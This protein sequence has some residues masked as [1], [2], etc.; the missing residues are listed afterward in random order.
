MLEWIPHLRLPQPA[1]YHIAIEVL[2]FQLH[3]GLLIL[4]LLILVILV[5][6]LQEVVYDVGYDVQP[7]LLLGLLDPFCIEGGNLL[8]SGQ[9]L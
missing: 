5:L 7:L 4:Y 6:F 3:N 9:L 2:K 8:L 1:E